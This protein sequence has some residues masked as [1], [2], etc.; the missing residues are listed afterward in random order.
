MFVAWGAKESDHASMEYQ[1]SQEKPVKASHLLIS[2][3][4]HTQL[5]HSNY[6]SG[7]KKT[8][9]LYYK[10]KTYKSLCEVLSLCVRYGQEH[11]LSSKKYSLP[12]SK[13]IPSAFD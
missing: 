12:C 3:N 6:C 8:M 11:Y 13:Q 1:T 7:M 10:L 5:C 9:G 4:I 2:F